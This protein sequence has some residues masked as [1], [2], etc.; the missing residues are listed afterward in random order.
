M[1]TSY[2]RSIN[3]ATLKSNL[4]YEDQLHLILALKNFF[5]F[6]GSR[7]KIRHSYFKI[8]YAIY[9]FMKRCLKRGDKE[10]FPTIK[11]LGQISGYGKTTISQFINSKFFQNFGYVYQRRLRNGKNSSNIYH[12]FPWVVVWFEFFE[13]H[14]FMKDFKTDHNK[15]SQ[16]FEIRL[17]KGLLKRALEQENF[18][19]FCSQLLNSSYTEQKRLMNNLSTKNDLKVNAVESL[20][21]NA[22]KPKGYSSYKA[23]KE[24]YIRRPKENPHSILPKLEKTERILIDE[25]Q[26]GEVEVHSLMNNNRPFTLQKAINRYRDHTS[27]GWKPRSSVAYFTSLLTPKSQRKN[28]YRRNL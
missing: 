9:I 23:S 14:G 26:L 10:V 15:W 8:L 19:E 1:A 20:I 5:I 3:S 4:T 17:R 7:H 27:T 13:K 12:L 22:I 16:A 25:F 2:E 24:G 18:S 28:S 21:P 6:D 11:T